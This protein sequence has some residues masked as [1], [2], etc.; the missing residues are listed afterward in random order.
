MSIV[1]TNV[2]HPELFL[3]P[4]KNV[5]ETKEV[6]SVTP[7]TREEI[8]QTI[9]EILRTAKKKYKGWGHNQQSISNVY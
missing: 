8:D 7:V 4:F 3:N 6:V 1:K 5:Q 2:N 9:I